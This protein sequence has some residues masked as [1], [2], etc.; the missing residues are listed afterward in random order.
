[1]SRKHIRE[2]ETTVTIVTFSVCVIVYVLLHCRYH[3]CL[4]YTVV[5]ECGSE[6]NL[7]VRNAVPDLTMYLCDK[8]D[9]LSTFHGLVLIYSC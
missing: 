9:R 1:M 6:V 7:K 8:L 3:I 4:M 5:S 2:L